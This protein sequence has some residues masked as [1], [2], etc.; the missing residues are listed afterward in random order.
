[1]IYFEVMEI[2]LKTKP[3]TQ[4]AQQGRS[5]QVQIKPQIQIPA[6]FIIQLEATTKL[7][8]LSNFVGRKIK[9]KLKVCFFIHGMG[10]LLDL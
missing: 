6:Q 4:F 5:G 10:E 1:M 2:F 8:I 7:L 3:Q 9:V